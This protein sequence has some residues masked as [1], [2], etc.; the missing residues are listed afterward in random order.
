M[1]G[2]RSDQVQKHL[3]ELHSV[4]HDRRHLGRQV[5]VQLHA[6]PMQVGAGQDKDFLESA[7]DV[8]RHEL[9]SGFPGQCAQTADHVTRAVGI[10]YDLHRR[11]AGRVAIRRHAVQPAQA[12]TAADA[13]AASGWLISWAIE[14]ASSPKVVTRAACARIARP[15][16]VLPR[17]VWRGHVHH[18]ADELQ[19]IGLIADGVADHMNILDSAIGISR[20]CSKSKSVAVLELAR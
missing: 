13:M 1:P 6:V 8:E 3:L 19:L 2:C 20:R 14:A 18:R 15:Y 5:R 12:G 16:A 9:R 17:H 7:I 11:L 4:S 10:L